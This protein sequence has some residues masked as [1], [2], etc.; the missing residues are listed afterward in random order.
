M[1]DH[2]GAVLDRSSLLSVAG[3]LAIATSC[4][5]FGEAGGDPAPA[6]DAGGVDGDAGAADAGDGG[7][8]SLPAR[9]TCGSD[10]CVA[11]A[12]C[13]VR[14]QDT[15]GCETEETKCAGQEDLRVRCDGRADC[16]GQI[17]CMQFGDKFNVDAVTCRA[18]CNGPNDQRACHVD[19]DECDGGRCIDITE[20]LSGRPFPRVDIHVCQR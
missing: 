5:S 2:V 12:F 3:A 16:P 13:C 7:I 6:P 14:A 20:Q 11:P 10:T 17:C 9:V 18:E 1:C 19:K 4:A 8:T 15:I